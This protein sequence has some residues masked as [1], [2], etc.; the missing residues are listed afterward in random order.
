MVQ[1]YR[2][3]IEEIVT[4]RADNARRRCVDWG[5]L[6]GCDIHPRMRI[7]SLTIEEPSQTKRTTPDPF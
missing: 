5:T 6:I 1:Y 2:V 3:A 4:G 7:S